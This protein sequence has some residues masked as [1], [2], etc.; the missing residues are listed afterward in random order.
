MSQSARAEVGVFA[1]YY[2][3][4]V[5]GLFASTL[6]DRGPIRACVH[7]RFT[8]FMLTAGDA[9]VWCRGEQHVLS[10]GRLLVVEPGDV[11]R[12]LRK[13]RYAALALT[14][15][16]ELAR[17]FVDSSCN[18][19]LPVVLAE[20]PSLA[21]EL[22]ALIE[23]IKQEHD[24]T[25]QH[26]QLE[27]LF[28]SLEPLRT[29]LPARPEPPLV[30]RA[31]RALTEPSGSSLSLGELGRRLGCAPGYLCR[32]FS[33]HTGV[34]P[35]T[36]QLQ[37]RLLEAARLIEGGRTVAS[38]AALVGFGDESHLR[39]HFRRRFGV[40]PGRYQKALCASALGRA[41]PV[42]AAAI[43][44]GFGDESQLRGDFR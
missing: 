26:R 24:R 7:D 35:H 23:A 29:P 10:P 31:R 21:G 42:A 1:S 37:H 28:R 39:R 2:R 13:T 44:S 4:R 18:A 17:S 34:G 33:E 11:H 22:S 12:E 27:G 14:F 5:S 41:Q 20:S 19:R 30:A 8:L 43:L 6:V 16:A 40:P 32:V 9:V 25:R 36:Y 15:S 3:S 38:A